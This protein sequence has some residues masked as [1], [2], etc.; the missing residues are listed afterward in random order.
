MSQFKISAISLLSTAFTTFGETCDYKR[1]LA[2]LSRADL[3][4]VVSVNVAGR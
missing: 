2:D 4:A 3:V 1:A